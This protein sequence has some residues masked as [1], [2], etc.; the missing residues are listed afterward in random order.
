MDLWR[1]ARGCRPSREQE[2]LLT[3]A[4]REGR[5]ALAAWRVW[6]TNAKMEHL[7]PASQRLL[8]QVYRN[9]VAQGLT[10]WLPGRLKSIY[11]Y[12]W[13]K[14]QT[15][16]HRATPVLQA[17]QETGIRT[18]ILKGLALTA[19]YY[20]DFG[21]RPIDTVDVLAPKDQ[22]SLAMALLQDLG[23][24]SDVK[25]L[26]SLFPRGIWSRSRMSI[27]TRSISTGNLS[28]AA[29]VPVKIG[30]VSTGA[31]SPVDQ[32]LGICGDG[33]PSGLRK[34]TWVADALVPLNRPAAS[35]ID[36][37]RFIA[38]VRRWRLTLPVA[39]RLRYLH[40][41]WTAPVPA[42][43]CER[44]KKMPVSLFERT[45]HKA[46]MSPAGLVSSFVYH[47]HS[48]QRFNA[49][50]RHPLASLAYLQA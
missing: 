14:N 13:F 9:L 44:L 8:P 21:A 22:A 43:V 35:I 16:V 27:A 31:L 37:G 29:A 48:F 3:A 42:V 11:R 2:L 12:T 17:L 5:E 24:T 49:G 20:R 28:G 41:R 32:L 1:S 7:D 25:C 19:L 15:L 45:M 18:L 36:W 4:L 30:A 38:R 10:D 47:W 34:V 50:G 46:W 23:W 6:Q 39:E 40:D 33:P 26:C